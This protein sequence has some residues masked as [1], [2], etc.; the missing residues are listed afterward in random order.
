VSI[1]QWSNKKGKQ[2]TGWMD[3]VECC[4][5][6]YNTDAHNFSC[7]VIDTVDIA[8]DWCTDYICQ[9]NEISHPSEMG[10]GIAYKS[11]I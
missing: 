11:Y 9:M 3:V 8:W 2:P 4:R 7:L 6:L 5:E 1:N 10:F